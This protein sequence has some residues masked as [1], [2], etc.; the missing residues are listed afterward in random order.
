MSG[1]PDSLALTPHPLRARVLA[2][3]HARPFT[4]IPTPSRLLRYAFMASG[5]TAD[6]AVAALAAVCA[7]RGLPGPPPDVRHFAVDLDFARL[8]FERH[9]EF[10]SYTWRF[11]SGADAFVPP[12][13]TLGRAMALVP[14][15]GPLIA[16]IDL[17]VLP[18]GRVP[19]LDAIFAGPVV[20]VSEVDGDRARVATDFKADVGGFVR[21]LVEDRNLSTAGTG[22]LVQRLLEAETYRT[23]ALLGLPEAQA[24]AP[25]LDRVS[26]DLSA[27]TG[28]AQSQHGVEANRRLLD[29][30]TAL[31]AE[32][33]R[34]ATETT[35]RFGATRAYHELVEA[36]LDTIGERPV[37][38][39]STLG[40]FLSR[41]LSPAF[42]T[43]AAVEERLDDLS[44]KLTRFADLLR[45]RVNIELESQN[46]Q[47]I[48]QMSERVRLQLRLQ[49][50]VE[51]LSVA[52]I[53]YYVA[54][55]M[56]LIFE[57]LH[58]GGL[59]LDPAIATA[60]VVPVVAGA[61]ALVVWRIRHHHSI[62]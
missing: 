47:Q 46:A 31:A 33:E 42:R 22:A 58:A 60:A 30:L 57:G 53:T 59:H 39:Y 18:Q 26:A 14:Q 4:Q 17:H 29:Q 37:A 35:F 34:Q 9:N 62:D 5:E 36:R 49:Q 24:L 44:L 20:A 15:P 1:L 8:R 32:V 27:L 12:A 43:C 41:R 50:T 2:E 38:P 61:V 3:L 45:T 23:L 54:S 10:L 16:A 6:A 48:R 7:K 13:E 51:G 11:P 19:D 28:E 40:A 55:V 56:H 25:V 52:A 21:I